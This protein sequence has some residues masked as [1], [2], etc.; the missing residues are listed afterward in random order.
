[1]K[2]AQIIDSL[3]GGG[4][5]RIAVNYANG[6]ADTIGFSALVATRHEGFMKEQLT[7]KVDYFFLGKKSALDFGAIIRLKAFVKSKE[8]EIVHAHGTSFFT[9]VLLKLI[10]PKIKIVWHEHY[11]AR[12]I[13]GKKD[14]LIL[15]FSSIFF[16]AIFVVNHQLEFWARKNLRVKKVC[17][18]P[19]FACFKADYP[20]QT[21]LKGNDGKRIVLVANLKNPKNHIAALA[22]F[23]ELQ[24]KDSGWSLHFVGKD[25]NDAYS[26]I[27]KD[28]V[29]AKNLKNDVFIYGAKD[30]VQHI[31]AQADIGILSSTTEGF[32]VVLLEYGLAKLPVVSTN[33]GFCPEI[34]QDHSSGLLF[35][36]LD[37]NQFKVQLSKM[38]SDRRLRENFGLNLHELVL[39]NYSEAH[40]IRL[41]LSKYQ[42]L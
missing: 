13:Q 12:A 35:D 5:E 36:P 1:M 33:A 3:E 19:N 23:H 26:Q 9:A 16:A 20:K 25:Y 18:I 24:L 32:P 11:G 39:K 10:Y 29:I 40:I 4:A 14:N 38:V 15:Y 8:I 31:L 37:K 6:L 41:L 34:V 17:Y 28:F 42:S 22:A 27:L 2:I 7:D 30:D 21:H